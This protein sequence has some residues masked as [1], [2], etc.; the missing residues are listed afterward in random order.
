MKVI[1]KINIS[2]RTFIINIDDAVVD[3]EK[4]KQKI[5]SFITDEMTEEDIENLFNE[6][7]VYSLV[8]P[9]AEII[10][11]EKGSQIKEKL[12]AKGVHQLLEDISF[13]YVA[14]NRGTE[15]LIKKTGRWTKEKIEDI[16]I[17]LPEGA[18]ILEELT[19]E[20]KQEVSAQEEEERIS[21]LTPEEKATEKRNRLHALA[22]E[23]INKEQEAAILE[24]PFD[25]MAWLQP[26]KQEIERLFA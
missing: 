9:E 1:T 8:G 4:T 23:A 19:P 25:R 12:D 15:Y 6:N 26:Q 3:S 5:A 11:D 2:G 22:R 14:N 20:Q 17:D 13:Q 18:I 10:D 21:A 16:G 24:E 7:H